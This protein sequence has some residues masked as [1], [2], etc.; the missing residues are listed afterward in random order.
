MMRSGFS[1][2]IGVIAEV[3]RDHRNASRPRG[4]D[5]RAGVPDHQRK[6]RI[7]SS[8]ADR[9][10]KHFRVRLWCAECVLPADG[11]EAPRQ[12]ERIEQAHRE[13]FEFVGAHRETEALLFEPIEARDQ[14][15]E[16]TRMVG[17]MRRV[18]VEID[19]EQAVEVGGTEGNALGGKPAL[20]QHLHPAADHGARL[21][22]DDRRNALVG[23]HRVESC[24]EIGRGVDQRPVEIES[25]DRCG[26]GT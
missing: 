5:V 1:S 3:H 26:H 13:P 10:A 11:G 21:V 8:L 16:G 17:D 12:I 23:K 7:S 6:R 19:V 14:P 22:I 15:I 20:D 9:A 2:A 18:A 25:D 4:G 24:D